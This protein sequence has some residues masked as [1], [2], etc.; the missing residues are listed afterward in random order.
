MND[1]KR[2]NNMLPGRRTFMRNIL[3]GTFSA[4]LA[5]AN[6]LSGGKE[7]SDRVK[8]GSMNYRRLGRTNLMISEISLGGSPIPEWPILHQAF[9]RGVN[10]IDTSHGYQNGNSERQIGQLLK[11]VG[12]EKVH[13]GTKFHLRRNWSEK[14]IISSVEGSLGR[15]NTDYMDVLLI[16]GAEDETLLDNERVLSAFE[17]LKEQGKYR[18]RGLSCHSNHHNI[19]KKAVECGF[20]DMI[21]LG[22]NVFDIQE[23]EK[24][25]ETYDDYLGACGIRHLISLAKS[26]DVGI[27]AMKT[28][29]IGGRRQ[30]L[31]KYKT[32]TTTLYQAMLKWVLENRDISSAVIEMLT[33]EELEEDLGVIGKPLSERERRN[34][35]R[36]VVENSTDYCHMCGLCQKNCPSRVETTSI[37]RYLAYH[38]GYAKTRLAKESY[39]SLKPGHTASACTNCGECE[40][41]CPYGVSIRKKIREAH[42]LL[43]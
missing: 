3:F 5:S 14:S 12:R 24:E 33:F 40:K 8:K 21:Q 39:S 41:A 42:F 6:L 43:G 27:I 2:G 23:S 15:L 19:V 34:L 28:L 38:E 1:N 4:S 26:K 11:K 32:G 25:I 37:L 18:F 10:Y 13:V 35:F 20:Y 16:H 7:Q 31:E 36:F 17:K 9:E 22:Y 30:N 29:K